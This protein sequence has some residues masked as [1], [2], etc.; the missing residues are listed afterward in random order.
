[1]DGDFAPERLQQALLADRAAVRELIVY[2]LPVVRARVLRALT[3]RG[4]AQARDPNQ[5]LDDVTQEVLAALFADDAR[6][7]RSWD[8]ARGLSLLNFVGLVSERQAAALFRTGKRSPWTEDPTLSSELE[9]LSGASQAPDRPLASREQ[10]ALILERLRERLSP[11]G[12][13][14]FYDLIVEEKSVAEVSSTT[15][16][17]VDALY[18]WRSRLGRLV[19]KIA[20]EVEPRAE[21][22]SEPARQL[23]RPPGDV[24]P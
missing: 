2:V 14:L 19:Q 13:Q 18:A 24:E 8:R 22:L 6:V 1:M 23:Q 3:R 4:R 5:E 20:H 12:L 17:S 15:G 9:L 10:L 11:L 21:A 7:L 16:M